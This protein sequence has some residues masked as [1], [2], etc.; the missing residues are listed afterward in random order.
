MKPVEYERPVIWGDV[1][2]NYAI[3]IIVI[4]LPTQPAIFC[5]HHPLHL[6]LTA[7]TFERTKFVTRCL[8]DILNHIFLTY[9]KHSD[10]LH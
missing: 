4:K 2:I 6:Q 7:C 5:L 9:C 8:S 1:T 10:G 3:Q